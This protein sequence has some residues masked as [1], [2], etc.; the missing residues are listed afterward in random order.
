MFAPENEMNYGDQM[1]KENEV[2]S[3]GLIT[4]NVGDFGRY[5]NGNFQLVDAFS[6]AEVTKGVTPIL[7]EESRALTAVTIDGNA[8]GDFLNKT[9][10][11]DATTVVDLITSNINGKISFGVLEVLLPKVATGLS[12]SEG[13]SLARQLPKAITKLQ[14]LGTILLAVT[15]AVSKLQPGSSSK[16]NFDEAIIEEI[17]DPITGRKEKKVVR[18]EPS[19]KLDV[20][21]NQLQAVAEKMRTLVAATQDSKDEELASLS[22]SATTIAMSASGLS[23]ALR[24]A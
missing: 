11:K 22:K 10:A 16:L 12:E 8:L 6:N 15:T 21:A 4:I 9:T 19:N 17:V 13:A 23:K 2:V 14:E 3:P 1:G 18:H 20:L 24:A 5:D 7:D